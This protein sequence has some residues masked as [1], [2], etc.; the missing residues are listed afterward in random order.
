MC[1]INNGDIYHIEYFNVSAL[2][3]F[4]YGVY[5]KVVV[6][7][8]GNNYYLWYIKNHFVL[9]TLQCHQIH[10][11]VDAKMKGNAFDMHIR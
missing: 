2:V 6:A 7:W 10:E 1:Q 9:S 3:D 4:S 8:Q 11:H 5:K